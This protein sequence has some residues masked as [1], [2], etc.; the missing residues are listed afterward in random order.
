VTSEHGQ[1]TLILSHQELCAV[2]GRSR[3]RAQSRALARMGISH[4]LRP[5]G[6][7]IV[8]RTHFEAIMGSDTAL[9]SPLATEPN[10][11]ALDAA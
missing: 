10:W 6:F 7:P 1:T 5:D 2:T 3:Y 9:P 11:G 8:S 4:R